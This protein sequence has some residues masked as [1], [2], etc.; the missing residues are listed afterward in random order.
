[1]SVLCAGGAVA[2]VLFNARGLAAND[3]PPIPL[4]Q[5]AESPSPTVTPLPPPI[6]PPPDAA[7]IS[8]TTPPIGAVSPQPKPTVPDTLWLTDG[9]TSTVSIAMH[10][11]RPFVPVV[12]NGVRHDFLLSTLR[13]TA[14]DTSLPVGGTTGAYYLRTLQIGDVRLTNVKVSRQRLA[15]YSRTYLG[16]EAGGVLGAELFA[17]YPVSIDY[18]KRL[19]TIYRSTT[20]A[21]FGRPSGSTVAPMQMVG[22]LPAV[23]CAVD[24]TNATPCFLNVGS[25]VD[26]ALS[27]SGWADKND[28]ATLMRD[29]EPAGEVRGVVFRAHQLTV[30]QIAVAAPVVELLRQASA[31]D[32]IGGAVL[33]AVVGSGAL[34]RFAVTID[35]PGGAFVVSAD[36][37]AASQPSAFDGS[38]LWLV[39]RNN[40]VVVRSVVSKSAADAAGIASGDV[41]LAIDGRPVIDLDTARGSLMRPSGTRTT[42][43]YQRGTTRHDVALILRSLI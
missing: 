40:M 9:D 19:M 6:V 26:L 30:G 39:S 8:A 43:T 18:P 17:R 29:A 33:H 2:T 10:G 41:I 23:T 12:V 35:E 28:A 32:H 1:M 24:G 11:G 21:E 37:T 27:G 20:M 42:V 22:G 5:S 16:A 34:S 38:G 25:D 15:P 31:D 4:V 14:V 7:G 36:P 3:P 13:A